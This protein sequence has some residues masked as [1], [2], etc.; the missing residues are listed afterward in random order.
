M[1]IVSQRKAGAALAAGLYGGLAG[2]AILAG[3]AA[4]LHRQIAS[5]TSGYFS[6]KTHGNG[7]GAVLRRAF[8]GYAANGFMS[9]SGQLVTSPQQAL[10]GSSGATS[11][12]P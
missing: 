8:G 9:P 6:P 3:P 2:A 4:V 10:P 7:A 5:P 11:G 1:T 12:R